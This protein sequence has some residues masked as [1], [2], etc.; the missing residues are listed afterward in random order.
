MNRSLKIATLPEISSIHFK[1][2]DFHTHVANKR[3]KRDGKLI[4]HPGLFKP[5]DDSF[6][7]L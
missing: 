3:E 5:A 7:Y 4:H 1:Y 6:K 2:T